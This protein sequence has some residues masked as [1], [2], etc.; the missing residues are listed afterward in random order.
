MVQTSPSSQSVGPPEIQTPSQQESPSVQASPSLQSAPSALLFLQ[1]LAG[2]QLS[3]V[4]T[5]PSSQFSGLPPTHSA[6]Q[7]LSPVVQAL[8]S[9]QA[10]PLSAWWTQPLDGWQLSAV[11]TLPSSQ[12]SASPGAHF[13]SQQLS[14]V[15]QALPSSQAAPLSAALTQPDL[16]SQLS[17]VQTLPSSQMMA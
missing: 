8:P 10:P 4:Q 1:P 2:W 16:G 12:S 13:L 9:S 5:L 17:A 3:V 14:P 11:Q 6:S 15:V 7:Q